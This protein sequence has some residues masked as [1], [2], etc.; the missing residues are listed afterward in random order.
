M[1]LPIPEPAASSSPR[2]P[3]KG[4]AP[5]QLWAELE[6]IARGDVNWRAGR[7]Q[8]YVYAVGDDVLAVAKE[9]FTRFFS[10]SPLSPRIF[11]SMKR[12]E[13]DLV[14]MSAGLLHARIP[15]GTVTTGGT[16]SNFLAVLTAREWA[17]AHRPEVKQ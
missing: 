14:G 11:P 5:D 7:L 12:L 4:R 6:E 2:L 8:G 15:A 10:T 17:R 3:A 16:E 13:E 1:S 9:A